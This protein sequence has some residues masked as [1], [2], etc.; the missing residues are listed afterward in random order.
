MKQLIIAPHS[1][2]KCILKSLRKNDKFKDVLFLD[3]NELLAY[4]HGKI[5]SHQA[6]KFLIEKYKY[7]YFRAHDILKYLPYIN[8]EYTLNEKL[9]ELLK[10]KNELISSNIL[11]Y[12]KYD[13]SYNRNEKAIVYYPS[14]DKELISLMEYFSIDYVF[15]SFG[16]S[17]PLNVEIYSDANSELLAVLSHV[18]DLLNSGVN[19]RKIHLCNV[20]DHHIFALKRLAN[21]YGININMPDNLS[22][23]SHPLVYSYLNALDNGS[24]L[25]DARNEIID[26]ILYAN[27]DKETIIELID[28]F[29]IPTLSN[30]EQISLYKSVFLDKKIHEPRYVEAINVDELSMFNEDDYIFILNFSEDTCPPILLGDGLILDD[31]KKAINYPSIEDENSLKKAIFTSLL[32]QKA[33]IYIS[34]A[35][36][37]NNEKFRISPLVNEL[38]LRTS[39]GTNTL[40]FYSKKE[41]L[42]Y[43][44]I[45]EDFYRHYLS[46]LKFYPA[47]KD[48]TPDIDE[49][50]SF[51]HSYKTSTKYLNLKKVV[52]SYTLLNDYSLCPFRYYLNH[53]LK[54]DP[55]VENSYAKIGNFA[56]EIIQHIMDNYDY[57]NI[58][59]NIKSNYTF[60]P[61]QALF[62]PRVKRDLK[63]TFDKLREI[64][65]QLN[66]TKYYSELPFHLYLDKFVEVKGRIDTVI[67]CD[68]IQPY[69]LCVD[70]K[71]KSSVDAIDEDL[72]EYGLSMQLPTYALA[73]SLDNDLSK[74]H[75][76]G[77]YYLKINS[78]NTINKEEKIYNDIKLNGIT[79][80]D[81]YPSL[82][83]MFN[84][85]FKSYFIFR[86]LPNDNVENARFKSNDWFVDV[87][88]R[89]KEIYR[90][91]AKKII[92]EDFSIS[93]ISINGDKRGCKY[94]TFKD[95]CFVTDEDFRS[96]RIMNKNEEQDHEVETGTAQRD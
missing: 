95:I 53:I 61:I 55:F 88:K 11:T 12:P 37:S 20:A 45:N 86:S 35:E 7:D 87:I 44:S 19:A 32:S 38:N 46:N 48:K 41:M 81:I 31:E 89:T 10:I 85:K 84:D 21:N 80:K 71:F 72:F 14:S 27:E 75:I 6:L 28:D 13:L 57:D 82:N 36:R 25:E 64:Y 33:N 83:S 62:L 56:H 42:Y 65:S 74:Q 51:N 79:N 60:E 15:Y 22:L 24:S 34:F 39:Y 50:L 2:H 43:Y 40:R 3:K 59:A 90:E 30:E 1:F 96:I 29:N 5:D 69:L 76:G 91:T 17:F 92:A 93:P 18:G 26:S 70:Y 4:Y 68:G 49:Y 66:F 67:T 47:L 23:L 94:C 77:L 8:E 73:L 54:I 58:Y 16:D 9:K 63:I 78:S 52:L